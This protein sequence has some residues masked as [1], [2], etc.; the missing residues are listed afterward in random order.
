[1]KG[2]PVKAAVT[3]SC[4]AV[5]A[6]LAVYYTGNHWQLGASVD[7]LLHKHVGMDS[8]AASAS[9]ADRTKGRVELHKAIRAPARRMLVED[10][11]HAGTS[12]KPSAADVNKTVLVLA[13]FREDLEWLYTRQPYDFFVISKCCPALGDTPHTLSINRG[14]EASVYFKFIVEHYDQLPARLIF[15]HAHETSH[16]S[17]VRARRFETDFV[18]AFHPPPP[19]HRLAV[20]SQTALPPAHT[21]LHCD[22]IAHAQNMSQILNRLDVHSYEYVGLSR[23]YFG[24]NEEFCK[25]IGGIQ[26][27]NSWSDPP[28]ML[29]ALGPP[30]KG[31][32]ALC[33]SHLV[34]S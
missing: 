14:T 27:R 3:L 31:V 16:H 18:V 33:C 1:M 34:H 24:V 17:L 32:C 2:A 11:R 21:A 7:A 25:Y 23:Q 29:E 30:P 9:A 10:R 15:L 6:C 8:D 20:F 22:A 5:L 26:T 13:H 28:I 12:W 4:A 19:L